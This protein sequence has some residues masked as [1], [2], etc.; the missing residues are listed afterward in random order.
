MTI[1]VIS[2]IREP[3]G[4]SEELWYQMAK[5]ALIQK[6]TVLHLS[7]DCGKLHPK[8]EELIGMGMKE[9]Q[10]PSNTLQKKNPVTQIFYKGLFFLKKRLNRSMQIIFKQQPDIVLYNG[11]CYSIADENKLMRH[12]YLS[13][14]IFFIIGHF[15]DERNSQMSPPLKE[16]IIKAYKRCKQVFFVAQKTRMVVQK[17]LSADIPNI[18]IVRN[19]VNLNSVT[20]IPYPV[21]ATARLAMVA[22]LIIE[23]KGQD[24]VLQILASEKWKTR[25]IHLNIYGTGKDEKYLKQLVCN[26]KLETKVTFYGKVNNIEQVWAANQILLMP[27]HME[28]MPLALVEA[29]LCGRTAVVTDVG[30][31]AECIDDTINGFVAGADD[32]SAFENAMNKAYDKKSEWQR[33]GLLAHDKA[34]KIYDAEAGK[35]LLHL[36]S[37]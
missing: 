18:S 24:I 19:P 20:I 13:N 35:T 26:L 12:V 22:N 3:W 5:E 25:D 31:N 27:S 32:I 34:M 29:M 16:R 9:Y 8:T 36:I 21:N 15:A 17:Q 4:G 1:A 11:T 6:H 23:H 2:M 30:G 7:Y 10:R 37:S 28:G 33:L 14:C